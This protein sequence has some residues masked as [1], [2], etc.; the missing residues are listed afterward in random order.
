M[1]QDTGIIF[2]NNRSVSD[3]IF[4]LKETQ[5]NC[6]E[7]KSVFYV[8]FK[9]A[10]DLVDRKQLYQAIRELRISR[11]SI[12]VIRMT[13]EKTRSEVVWKGH[14]SKEFEVKRG[15][16]DG[17]PVTVD[18]RSLCLFSL[19]LEMIIRKSDIKTK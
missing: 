8:V 10:Y 3:Q 7:Y 17:D 19:V 11:K 15:L 16:E 6:Y 12:S 14:K 4:T 5:V 1:L 2:K 9:Q 18:I 13:L